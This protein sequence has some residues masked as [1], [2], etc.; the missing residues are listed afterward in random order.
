MINGNKTGVNAERLALRQV[1]ASSESSQDEYSALGLA[2]NPS[3]NIVAHLPRA[4]GPDDG[5]LFHPCENHECVAADPNSHRKRSGS[6]DSDSGSTVI[7]NN[8]PLVDPSK[9]CCPIFDE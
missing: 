8:H 5:V 4:V 9:L 7:H 3:S 6:N 2:P 1:N